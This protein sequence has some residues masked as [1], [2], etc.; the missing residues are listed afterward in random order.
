MSIATANLNFL[1]L[2]P[3]ERSTRPPA[4][5]PA[6]CVPLK[7]IQEQVD[8]GIICEPCNG[9]GWLLCD[10]CKGQKTNVKA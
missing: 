9:R 1:Q 7:Q 6:R 3:F 4:L 5:K 8:A 10:F 2:L